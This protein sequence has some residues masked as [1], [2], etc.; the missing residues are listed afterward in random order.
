METAVHNTLMRE[1]HDG[2][3]YWKGEGEI[4]LAI[5]HGLSLRSL[6]Q[7]T[8]EGLLDPN[9]RR[10]ELRPFAE[11]AVALPHAEPL[12]VAGALPAPGTGD[13]GVRVMALGRFLA[14]EPEERVPRRDFPKEVDTPEPAALKVLDHLRKHGRITRHEVTKLC[15]LTP[16]RATR[17][18][19]R[20]VAENKIK[21]RGAGRGT[22]YTLGPAGEVLIR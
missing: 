14:A 17:L 20:L 16:P 8:D 11:A 12:V 7:V 19:G 3:F 1:R 21:R 22:W 9:A 2:L 13:L 10:R 5:R 15:A 18:L 6:I 4:D